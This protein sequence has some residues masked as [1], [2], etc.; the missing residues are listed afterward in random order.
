MSQTTTT[1][2]LPSPPSTTTNEN[3]H[4]QW[5]KHWMVYSKDSVMD[6]LTE[7]LD[8][9][10]KYFTAC[11]DGKKDIVFNEKMLNYIQSRLQNIHN[12]IS[13]LTL[14]D[15]IP[16]DQYSYFDSI[17]GELESKFQTCELPE[18][19]SL[20]REYI[21]SIIDMEIFDDD[22][23]DEEPLNS[24]DENNLLLEDEL[25]KK[26]EF[27]LPDNASI[28]DVNNECKKRKNM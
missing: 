1:E 21:D 19:T 12:L 23:E 6:K 3:K 7:N 4:I 25:L 10:I 8:T 14:H 27:I 26:E 11:E 28:I 15:E 24:E 5:R 9:L 16:Q 18:R 2:I 13:S 17:Q 22:E 20:L